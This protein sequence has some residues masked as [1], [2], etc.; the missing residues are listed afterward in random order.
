MYYLFSLVS[1]YIGLCCHAGYERER[2]P[3]RVS[4]SL[5]HIPMELYEYMLPGES[6]EVWTSELCCV[7]CSVY[8]NVAM[9]APPP[10]SYSMV[11]WYIRLSYIFG[12]L[13]D[14]VGRVCEL[15]GCLATDVSS[16]V[17]EQSVAPPINSSLP[18]T[19]EVVAMDTV[20]G[21]VVKRYTGLISIL[22]TVGVAL[23][24]FTVWLVLKYTEDS[25]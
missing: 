18:S 6:V 9:G 15:T 25:I 11:V 2:L 4:L 5:P 22:A 16:A 7:H 21:A 10:S 20:D 24:A 12:L 3:C 14:C 23:L 1:L 8:I 17:L 13:Q 19:P